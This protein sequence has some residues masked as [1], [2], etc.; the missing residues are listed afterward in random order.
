MDDATGI[1]LALLDGMD[2]DLLG[3]LHRAGIRTRIDLA[4]HLATTQSRRALARELGVTLRRVETLHYLNIL[5][6]EERAG[7][8]LELEARV[9]EHFQRT[10]DGLRRVWRALLALGLLAVALVVVALLFARPFAGRGGAGNEATLDSLG[11]RIDELQARTES[12]MPLARR[13]LQALIFTHLSG[14]GPAPDWDGPL[15]WTVE[16]VRRANAIL[17]GDDAGLRER[18]VSLVLARLAALEN[19][20]VD[21]LPPAARAREAVGL[22]R[23]FPPL[24]D[25]DT[26]WDT[27]A[28]LL[29]QRLRSRAL[30]LAPGDAESPPAAAAEPWSW[31]APGFLACEELTARMEALPVGESALP[32]W[33][34]GLAQI[35]RAADRGREA[36]GA[37]PEGYARDYWIRRGELELAVVAAILGRGDLQPYHADSPRDF[38]RQRRTFLANSAANA[39]AQAAAPLYWLWLEYD[40]ADRLLDWLETHPDAAA[41]A[42]GKPWVE[43]LEVLDAARSVDGTR[44]DPGLTRTVSRALDAAGVTDVTDPWARARTRWESGLRPLLMV[45]RNACLA[46]R[47]EPAAAR[48]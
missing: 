10:Q 40:E 7:R 1:E 9:D 34:D 46:R 11:V 26:V 28:V 15:D 33:S 29:R 27:A 16:D 24:R 12:L 13:D 44:P 8:H 25:L 21:S 30:G 19:A 18:A 20:P 45:T 41:N 36:L 22:L 4:S 42:N 17:G 43:A 48:R 14:L 37:R 23:D 38:L 6:P 31:T 5:L 35:R 39:P 47:P 32:V 2:E 3:R